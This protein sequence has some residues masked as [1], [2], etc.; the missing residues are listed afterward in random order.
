MSQPA[1]ISGIEAA[2]RYRRALALEAK[3][4]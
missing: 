3:A 4:E 2:L 1:D